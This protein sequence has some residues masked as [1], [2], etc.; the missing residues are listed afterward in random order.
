MNANEIIQRARTNRLAALAAVAGM[1]SQSATPRPGCV[2]AAPLPM[3]PS[4]R[5]MVSIVRSAAN[6]PMPFPGPTVPACSRAFAG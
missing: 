4:S 2:L 5:R 1:C 6:F 3:L